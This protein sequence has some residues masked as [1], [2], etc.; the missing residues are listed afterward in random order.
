MMTELAADEQDEI[1]PSHRID[2]GMPR[3]LGKPIGG[4]SQ[5][6]QVKRGLLQLH[7]PSDRQQQT[8]PKDHRQGE[9][10]VAG[11]PLLR[12]RQPTSNDRNE[13]DIVDAED[14]FH[15][16]ESQ[17]RNGIGEHGETS[18]RYLKIVYVV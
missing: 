11:L 8:D 13:D 15:R 2:F 3:G 6:V 5:V 4:N 14:N 10:D 16:D 17:E 1:F 7:D 9:A 18:F 12:F